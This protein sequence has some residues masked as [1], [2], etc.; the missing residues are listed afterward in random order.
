MPGAAHDDLAN[1]VAMAISL[2]ML[3]RPIKNAAQLTAA[4]QKPCLDTLNRAACCT[5]IPSLVGEA[6]Y[7]SFPSSI[8]LGGAEGRF[9]G[10]RISSDASKNRNTAIPLQS[11][12]FQA[13]AFFPPRQL[14]YGDRGVR[15]VQRA[16]SR[17]AR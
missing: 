17:I 3:R 8:P 13:A 11:P 12:R 15:W 1:R 4:P 7:S 16:I 6:V 9:V 14:S 10:S 5:Y 2:V